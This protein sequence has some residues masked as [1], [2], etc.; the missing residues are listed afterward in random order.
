MFSSSSNV[1]ALGSKCFS[2]GFSSDSDGLR[3]TSPRHNRAV[4]LKSNI[5]TGTTSRVN[6][7][8]SSRRLK[9]LCEACTMQCDEK[10]IHESP[11][12]RK[13]QN[14]KGVPVF[15]MLPLDTVNFNGSLNRKRA[16]NASLLALKSAGVRG[17][18]VDVWWGLVEKDGPMQYNWSGYRELVD[19]V[20]KHGLELQAVMSFHQCG[21]NVG[22]SCNIPLPGWVLQEVHQNPDMVYTDKQ[23]RRN[24]EYISLGCDTMPL[25]KGRSPIQV[26]TDYMASFRDT[27][28]DALGNVI[29]EIQVGMG[30]CGELRY[31]SYPESNGTWRF[32]GIGEFQCYD[33]YMKASLMA[34]AEAAGQ[35]GWGKTGPHDSGYYSQFPEDAGFFRR[36]GTWD[37]DYGRFFLKWYSETLL[38]H[39]DRL[40]GAAAG[41]FQGTGAKL[42][43]KVA[44]IHWHYGSKSHA[45]ELT[46]GYYNTRQTDGYLPIARLFKKHGVVL[47]FTCFEM[48]DYEHPQHAR[49][50][51]EGLLRQV[52]TV[53]RQNDVQ[54]AG[55]NALQRYDGGAYGQI[56]HNSNLKLQGN[57]E[58]NARPMNAFTYLRMN[59]Q[60]FQSE[61]WRQF[62]WFVRNMSEGRTLHHGEEEHRQTELKFNASTAL[63]NEAAALMHA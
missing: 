56:I 34:C 22:D 58:Q 42:S 25:L 28:K 17:V 54:I 9:T 40:L 10:L 26:Y 39:G 15:V 61:N 49:C 47:N 48:K 8:R 11:S 52:T 32:P 30:P 33:K 55:E 1:G 6:C 53:C 43:G 18:M 5:S 31:P 37:S 2:K 46:A 50:S 60:M 35:S 24:H 57:S 21:G 36:E 38:S 16:M 23:G 7:L 19:M 44:G 27:F 41:V 14:V 13:A 62:V 29:V 3:L 12:G 59:P 45:A 20:A 4:S 51:P 63:R